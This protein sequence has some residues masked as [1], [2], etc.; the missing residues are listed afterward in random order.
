MRRIVTLHRSIA[1]THR[2]TTTYP[3]FVLVWFEA[4]LLSILFV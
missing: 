1:T 2:H 3:E 4:S